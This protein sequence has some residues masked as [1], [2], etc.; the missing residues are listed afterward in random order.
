MKDLF[1][2]SFGQKRKR[3]TVY[4]MFLRSV[5]TYGSKLKDNE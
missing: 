4:T 5:W 2:P 3:I 1:E